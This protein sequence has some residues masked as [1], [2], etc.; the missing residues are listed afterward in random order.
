MSELTLVRYTVAAGQEDRNAE[1]V[2]AVYEELGR[3]VPDG[4]RYATLREGADFTHVA[5]HDGRRAAADGAGRVP[6][7][8]GGTA[9]SGPSRGRPSRTPS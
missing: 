6:G 5:L 2:R 8:P 9:G 7:L 3:A 4:F 1:L